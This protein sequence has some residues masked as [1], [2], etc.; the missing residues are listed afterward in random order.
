[1]SMDRR[2]FIKLSAMSC[3]GM[4]ATITFPGTASGRAD[5]ESKQMNVYLRF[6]AD[7][8]IVYRDTKPEMGQGISTGLAMVVCDALGADWSKFVIEKPVLTSNILPI[9]HSLDE[10]AGSHGM[11]SAYRPLKEAA[12]SLR[13]M[14]LSSAADT[15]LCDETDCEVKNS[16]VYNRR[17]KASLSFAA[18]YPKVIRAK[19][20]ENSAPIQQREFSLIGKDIS[21]RENQDI[22]T[23]KQPFS[24]DIALKDMLHVS[25][26]RSP[27]TDG[28][29]KTFDDTECL[30]VKGVKQTLEMPAFP[31]LL[32]DPKDWQVK[33]RGTLAGVAVVADSSW[34]AMQGRRELTLSWQP[35]RYA[36]YDDEKIK[37]VSGEVKDKQVR[38]VVNSG[39]VDKVLNNSKP[40]NVYKARYFS[41]Y[42]ENAHLEPLNAVAKFDGKYLDIWAGSQS[43]TYAMDYAS[44]VTG[45][46]LD[47]IRFH[48]M[49]SGGAFG[50]RYFYDFI[51]EA[52]YVAVTLK[53][54]VK[55]TWSREDCVR[56]SRYHLCR[57]DEHTLVLDEDNNPVSMGCPNRQWFQLWLPRA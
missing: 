42:Q 6:Q 53:Q 28:Q 16:Q 21:I 44:Y 19:L 20:P 30:A 17:R 49:R 14:L 33:Y 11:L 18:L 4:L 23:G 40:E 52:A 12:N 54:A 46:P 47:K 45:V 50:R 22:V 13:Q 38:D 24:I 25:I 35:S 8:T 57:H 39:D 43:P 15:W 9:E 7:G 29:I 41:P 34:A 37:W 1:M 56:H 31:Q 3:G 27:F 51:A 48:S 32:D 26:E 36:G 2:E 5:P 55:V 10:S